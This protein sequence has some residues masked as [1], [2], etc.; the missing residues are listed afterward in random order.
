MTGLA[1]LAAAP[2]AALWSLDVPPATPDLLPGDIAAGD[3]V[4]L[5]ELG[6]AGPR[7]AP[8]A[9]VAAPPLFRGTMANAVLQAADVNE[10]SYVTGVDDG[11]D[12]AETEVFDGRFGVHRF[13]D[14]DATAFVTMT[15]PAG[16]S[17]RALR[18]QPLTGSGSRYQQPLILFPGSTAQL[19]RLRI[20]AWFQIAETLSSSLTLPAGGANW[21]TL[22]EMKTGDVTNPGSNQGNGDFRIIMGWVR[23]TDGVVRWNFKIDNEAN[24]SPPVTLP[25]AAETT[26]VTAA[27]PA[28]NQWFE[29]DIH[30]HRGEPGAA[31]GLWEVRYNGAPI[32][33]RTGEMWGGVTDP[34]NRVFVAQSYGDPSLSLTT[35]VTD[36]RIEDPNA[37]IPGVVAGNTPTGLMAGLPMATPVMPPDLPVRAPEIRV[38]DR[39]W[40]GEPT[41]ATAPNAIYPARL[42]QQP[43]LESVL[44]VLPDGPRRASFT[45]GEIVLSNADGLL[46]G[47]AGDW[48][49]G[50][51][52]VTLLR[53]PHLRPRH[54]PYG[55]FVQVAK[56]RAAG[57]ASGTA[58]LTIPLVDAVAALN[59]PACATYAG[60][61]GAEG[62]ASLAGQPKPLALGIVRQVEPVLEDPA[63]LIYRAHHGG[64]I[65]SWLAVRDRGVALSF[66]SNVADYAALQAASPSSGTY[67]TCLAEGCIRLGAT[68]SL[69]TV[70]IKGDAGGAGYS[71]G[72]PASIANKLLFGP[73]GLSPAFIAPA[74][75]GAWPVGEAGLYLRGGTVAE[76]MEA[77][78]AGIAGWWGADRLGRITGS[79]IAAP[80]ALSPAWSIETWMHRAPPEAV[81]GDDPP[82][83]RARIGYRALGRVLSGEDLAGSVS[84]ADRELWGK[85][86]QTAISAD[87]DTLAAYPLAEDPP[88]LVSVFDSL[89]DAEALALSLRDLHRVPRRTWRVQLNRAGVALAP[90]QA[91]RLTWPRH[92]LSGGR[93]LLVRAVSLRGD[94]TEALLWG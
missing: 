73:G 55:D 90:G 53:G 84:A 92:G 48:A 44:P 32:Y 25:F 70:D 7:S 78:A 88:E 14:T 6:V 20:R 57:A 21:R 56:L 81:A 61:G 65:E 39:G 89:S 9:P 75:F 40:I 93:T 76:A 35:Y 1:P 36:V 83:W 41:D 4:W 37:T 91:V 30:V 69:L 18:L 66:A 2:L 24:N 74:A 13:A 42:I 43:A 52:S 15:G 85:P 22:W 59:V 80:E 5:V 67:V 58:R 26:D 17:V 60:T 68:P 94:R 28:A 3:G 38:S 71:A 50:G 27:V 51:R 8:T 64:P 46:D 29:L 31:N 82:R 77:L 10:V 34:W 45:A 79:T 33:S 62:V 47:L 23:N 63:R 54:A 19:H 86:W 49:V 11:Y 12:W 87:L 16:G 72:T